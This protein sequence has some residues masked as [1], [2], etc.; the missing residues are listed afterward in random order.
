MWSELLLNRGPGEGGIPLCH[1]PFNALKIVKFIAFL[2]QAAAVLLCL[3]SVS[4]VGVARAGDELSSGGGEATVVFSK[5]PPLPIHTIEGAGGLVITPVAYLVNAG[6]PGTTVGLPSIAATYV[7]LGDKDLETVSIS[8]TFFGRVELGYAVSRLGIGS[9]KDDVREVTTVSIRDNVVLHN[10][11]LRVLVL[12]ENSFD[13]PLPSI[14]LGASYKYNEGIAEINQQLGG[15]LS[16]IGYR[17]P[18]S[19]DFTLTA[20]KELPKIAGHHLIA[21][22]GLRMSEGEQIGYVG[23][24]NRYR[25]TFEGNLAFSIMDWLWLA[26]EFRGN[27]NAFDRMA[28]P[29]GG[30]LVDRVDN[31]WAVGVTAILS[32][33]TTATIG[34]GHLGRVLNDTANECIGAELKYEF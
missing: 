28:N 1:T 8:E 11:N 30:A 25:A 17:H 31:W 3:G 34:W 27:A 20:T 2:R 12:Q 22:G 29:Y 5:C 15:A 18:G 10:V 26:G 7:T 14:V 32:M 24:G 4:A 13:L 6:A 21:T 23:F 9:L 16:A 19:T 33:H